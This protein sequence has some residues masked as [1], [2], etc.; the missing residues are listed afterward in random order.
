MTGE[1]ELLSKFILLSIHIPTF[2]PK[3]KNWMIKNLH[4]YLGNTRVSDLA[5]IKTF[6]K[7]QSIIY[8]IT[9]YNKYLLI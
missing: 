9:I 7:T 2:H 4:F 5:F 8:E 3:C 6:T 1:Y